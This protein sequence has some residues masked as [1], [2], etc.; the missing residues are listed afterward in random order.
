MSRVLWV[1]PSAKDPEGVEASSDAVLALIRSPSGST[2]IAVP[3]SNG[4]QK[5]GSLRFTDWKG[6]T[7]RAQIGD[8]I[9]ITTAGW[10]LH[11]EG[12]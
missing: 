8:E 11:R 6:H 10:A 7:Q 12:S 1:D 4:I 9:E 3:A 5:D 2:P